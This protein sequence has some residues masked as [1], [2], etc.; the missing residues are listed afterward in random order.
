[1]SRLPEQEIL[2]KAKGLTR[3][4]SDVHVSSATS[5]KRGIEEHYDLCLND[6]TLSSSKATVMS[7]MSLPLSLFS[8]HPL[9]Q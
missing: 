1:M 7:K 8:P 2:Q 6:E 4:E 9:K 3:T 5:G